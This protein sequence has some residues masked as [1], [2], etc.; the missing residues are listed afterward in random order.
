M[1]SRS[2]PYHVVAQSDKIDKNGHRIN[3]LLGTIT[4]AGY[5]ENTHTYVHMKDVAELFGF[6]V[7]ILT[8][9]QFYNSCPRHEVQ[10]LSYETIHR[11]LWARLR[12]RGKILAARRKDKA[13]D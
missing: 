9:K 11:P 10:A 12:K 8:A 2:R 4:C 7:Q 13:N 3:M 6:D 1:L 5:P